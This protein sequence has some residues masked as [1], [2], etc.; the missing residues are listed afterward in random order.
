[1]QNSHAPQHA[2]SSALPNLVE[3]Q[4][5]LNFA[6][7]THFIIIYLSNAMRDYDPTNPLSIF[8]YSTKLIDYTIAQIIP[9]IDS[10]ISLEELDQDGKGGVGILVEKYFFG[11]DPNSNPNAD[12]P[13]AGVELK[14]TPLKK[15]KNDVLTIKERLVCDMI[16]YFE[17]VNEKFEDSRFWRKS[18]LILILFYLHIKGCPKRDLQFLYSILWKIKDKDLLIIQEDFRIIQNKIKTGKAHELSE[19][20]TMYLGA[21]RKGSS[22][23]P[24]R[25]QPF[26]DVLAPA[27]AFSLKPAY[28]R[29]VLDFVRNSGKKATTNLTTTEMPG[30]EL[31]S[32]QEL[33]AQSF[34]DILRNRFT[35]FI[36][37][38]YKQIGKHFG[39]DLKAND[40]S[41][42]ANA[43]KNIILKGIKD[44]NQAE[45]IKKSGIKIKTIRIQKTGT[46]REH[47]SFPNIDYAEVL[48]TEDWI[49]SEWYEICTTRYM[50]IIFREV[51]SSWKDEPRFVLDKMFFWTMPSEDYGEA[52]EYWLNIRH[53]VLEDT[54]LGKED[55]EKANSFWSLKDHKYFHVRPKA[56]NVLDTTK[57]PISGIPVPKKCYWF[58]KRYL[59]KEIR[60]AYGEDWDKIF[61]KNK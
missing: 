23:Q 1:M 18:M 41:R 25:K 44:V 22:G 16:D 45:E 47:M 20:D 49:D 43:A 32:C 6:D 21:C 37:Q 14:V 51:E 42:Y 55:G 2:R 13:E 53:N 27:R 30:V 29:S 61:N 56:K 57:S 50:F 11:Y 8:S 19:G 15:L 48:A 4:I 52:E 17:I 5:I 34:E 38:D 46:I 58:D 26:S 28:M 39:V 40:K 7:N 54:L 24:A 35:K 60:A 36:G 59:E 9:T 10:S 33:K 12:F 31:V 3:R